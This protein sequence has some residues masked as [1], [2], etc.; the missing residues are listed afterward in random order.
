MIL[1]GL[2]LLLIGALTGIAILW[3]LGVVVIVVGV[4]LMLLGRL[5][6]PVGS[7]AHYW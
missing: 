5:G 1:T 6:H 4:V 7:R 3:T 2:L